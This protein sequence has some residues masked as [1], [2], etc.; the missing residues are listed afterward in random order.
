QPRWCEVL[1]TP[2]FVVV[3]EIHALVGN[4]RGADLALSLERLEHLGSKSGSRQSLQR[5]GLSATCTPLNVAARF[6]AGEGRP[7]TIAHVQDH[8]AMDLIVEPLPPEIDLRGRRLGFMARL[9]D[10]LLPEL[11][12]NRSTL[13]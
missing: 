6:L 12:R 13:I 10:R 5:I 7:C 3:D 11:A 9:V 4:K 8:T 2:R 1:R